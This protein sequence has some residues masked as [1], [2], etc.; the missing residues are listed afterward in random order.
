MGPRKGRVGHALHVDVH[1][2]PEPKLPQSPLTARRSGWLCRPLL[3]LCSAHLS[4]LLS[5]GGRGGWWRCGASGDARS[6][7]TGRGAMDKGGTCYFNEGVIMSGYLRGTE[8]MSG[9]T[10]NLTSRIVSESLGH[11]TG[12]M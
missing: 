4:R 12:A 1:L 5:F 3:M 9:L 11:R 2:E 10:D 7:A 6:E 8:G